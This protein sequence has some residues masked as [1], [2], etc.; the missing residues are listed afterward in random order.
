MTMPSKAWDQVNERLV[1]LGTQVRTSADKMTKGTAID[2]AA[3][4]KSVRD[5]FSAIEDGFGLAGKAIRDPKIRKDLANVA[6]SVRQALLATMESAGEQVRERLPYA[7]G[8][9]SP[10]STDRKAAA[11]KTATRKPASVKKAATTKKASTVKASTAK[12][13]APVNKATPVNKAAPARKAT[14]GRSSARKRT[15]S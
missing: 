3:F 14:V 4:E 9:R 12:R 10:K 5:M 11:P 15:A 7:P 13:A 6:D 2:R 1:A 8:K